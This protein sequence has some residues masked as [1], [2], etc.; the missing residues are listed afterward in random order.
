MIY[1]DRL[2][3]KVCIMIE[4]ARWITYKNNLSD[5]SILFR[6]EFVIDKEIQSARLNICALGLGI[7]TINGKKVSDDVLCTPF[8]KYD[9]RVLFQSYDIEF[10]IQKGKK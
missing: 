5:Q 9:K 1:Y 8:T 7:Y 10:L 2:G 3:G 4:D 6:K